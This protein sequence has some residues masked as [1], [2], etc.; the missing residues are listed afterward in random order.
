LLGV[1]QTPLEVGKGR[2]LKPRTKLIVVA[3]E[4]AVVLRKAE[5]LVAK[6]GSMSIIQGVQSTFSKV[7]IRNI[8]E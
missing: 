1:V 6:R 2:D 4:D 8:E 5:A 3:T 7:L